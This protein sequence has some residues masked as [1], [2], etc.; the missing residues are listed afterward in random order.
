MIF[1]LEPE[2]QE[3]GIKAQTKQSLHV[4]CDAFMA[5]LRF[6]VKLKSFK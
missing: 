6:Y 3:L 4:K 1:L 5:C 2:I